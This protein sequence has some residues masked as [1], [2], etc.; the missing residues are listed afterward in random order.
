MAVIRTLSDA[1][2]E[3]LDIL[4]NSPKEA[5][6]EALET[7][8]SMR[9]ADIPTR[10][11]EFCDILRETLGRSA[12]PLLEFIVNQFYHELRVESIPLRD[13]DQSIER[14]GKILKSDLFVPHDS[15][16]TS[17]YQKRLKEK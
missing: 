16:H 6:Y 10:L 15:D 7:D 11:I 14:A 4:G 13:L 1:I 3:G 5:I 9:K 2:D 8:F 17:K 12:E